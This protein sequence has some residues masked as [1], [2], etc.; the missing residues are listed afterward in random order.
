MLCRGVVGC[1]AQ[2]PAFP[3]GQ[4]PPSGCS[5]QGPSSLAIGRRTHSDFVFH[6]NISSAQLGPFSSPTS[7][8]H[9]SPIKPIPSPNGT[10]QLFVMLEFLSQ[11][12]PTMRSTTKWY[13]KSRLRLSPGTPIHPEGPLAL[14]AVRPARA[15]RP[16]SS[17]AVLGRAGGQTGG[18]WCF[19]LVF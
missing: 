5:C 13:R 9:S 14:P 15:G 7:P 4:L 10:F 3:G 18:V 6:A 11:S 1:S 17:Y 2:V 16:V 19:Q 12:V 8:Q